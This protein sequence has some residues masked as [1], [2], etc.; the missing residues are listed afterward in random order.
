MYVVYLSISVQYVHM[1]VYV[2]K[3]AHL[4][5]LVYSTLPKD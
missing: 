1:Y 3:C 5:A 2:Q 4:A